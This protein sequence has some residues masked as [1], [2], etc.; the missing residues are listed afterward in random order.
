MASQHCSAEVDCGQF[1]GLAK[2]FRN[3]MVSSKIVSQQYAQDGV[4]EGREHHG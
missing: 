2:R 4:L 3:Q 1:G